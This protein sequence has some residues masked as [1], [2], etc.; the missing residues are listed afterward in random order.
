MSSLGGG[1]CGGCGLCGSG[2][3]PMT[4]FTLEEF[5]IIQPILSSLVTSDCEPTANNFFDW[6]ELNCSQA[7]FCSDCQTLLREMKRLKVLVKLVTSQLEAIVSK[8]KVKYSERPVWV[9][10]E[11]ITHDNV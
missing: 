6:T 1:G 3:S 9:K 10:A 11:E 8:V 5:E 2:N 7:A 4:N